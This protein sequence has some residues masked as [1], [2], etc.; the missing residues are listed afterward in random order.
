MSGFWREKKVLITGHTG[1]VGTWLCMVLSYLGADISGFSLKEEDSSLYEKIKEN[2]CVKNY[3]GDL[4]NNSEIEKCISETRPDIVYHLA[5]FGFIKECLDNPE[6]AYGTNVL[7]TLNLL[8]TIRK[9]GCVKNIIVASSDKVYKNE[10]LNINYFSEQNPLGG[11]DTY[12]CSKTAEDMLVQSYYDTYLSSQNIGVAILRPSNILGGGDH[13]KN[14][15][16][17]HILEEMI[18]GRKPKI[19]NP[20]AVRPWQHILDMTDAYIKVAEEY[21]GMR[22]IHIYNVGPEKENIVTVDELLK[23]LINFSNTV[24]SYE[25]ENFDN[26]VNQSERKFLGLS[27]EKISSELGWKPAKDIKQTL[28][29]TY[30]F[31]YEKGKQGEY[32]ICKKQIEDYYRQKAIV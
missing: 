13:N 18:N 1:F 14:R 25:V 19:R 27:I 15:L 8:E 22:G 23:N 5:A 4:R 12:S 17:P 2:I 10:D 16:I 6:R 32:C 30:M 3:Y 7:G 20:K 28:Y 29:D 26:K 21:Y 24:P 9:Y 11:I 31:E